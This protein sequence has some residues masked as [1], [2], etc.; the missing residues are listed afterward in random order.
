MASLGAQSS[1]QGQF[2]H[3]LPIK[4]LPQN[5]IFVNSSCLIRG[6]PGGKETANSGDVR[7]AGLIPGLGRSPEGG[8]G[9]PLQYS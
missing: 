1:L 8:P 9:K 5:A 3:F 7:Y 2:K 6:F 4:S